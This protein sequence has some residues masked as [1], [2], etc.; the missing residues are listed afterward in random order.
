MQFVIIYVIKIY[1]VY[2]NTSR[3]FLW[4]IGAW[5]TFFSMAHIGKIRSNTHKLKCTKF[6][7]S[8]RKSTFSM[9]KVKHWNGLLRELGDIQNPTWPW[10]TCSSWIWFKQRGWRGSR[11]QVQ[12]SLPHSVTLQ[13]SSEGKSPL[14]NF[15]T[16][17]RRIWLCSLAEF[18]K[19]ESMEDQK[20]L[21]VKEWLLKLFKMVGRFNDLQQKNLER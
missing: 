1:S 3:Y 7:L 15:S 19:S 5:A 16:Y 21:I 12:A 14:Y 6:H 18:M 20:K 13:Q 10:G 8:I 11:S 17:F 9:G 2:I 4:T